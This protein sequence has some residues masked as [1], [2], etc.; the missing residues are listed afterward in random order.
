MGAWCSLVAQGGGGGDQPGEG[1]VREAAG[2]RGLR[3]GKEMRE[4]GL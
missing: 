4:L 2:Q 3:C 1:Q